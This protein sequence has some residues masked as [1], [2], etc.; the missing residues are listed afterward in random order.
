M[1]STVGGEVACGGTQVASAAGLP[2][3]SVDGPSRQR[4]LTRGLQFRFAT[5]QIL[6]FQA[7]LRGTAEN[8]AKFLVAKMT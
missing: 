6:D 4:P 3:S 7:N 5:Q 2:E 8:S 1:R